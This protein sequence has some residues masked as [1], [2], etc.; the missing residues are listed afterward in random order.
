MSDWRP[1]WRPSC[2]EVD[3]WG[4]GGQKSV[5]E[6]KESSIDVGVVLSEKGFVVEWW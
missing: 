5:E 2:V 4:G 1:C 3:C 6:M